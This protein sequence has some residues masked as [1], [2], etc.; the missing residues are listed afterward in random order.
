MRAAV[1]VAGTLIALGIF[2]TIAAATAMDATWIGVGMLTVSIS[3]SV[4]V[5]VASAPR[6]G[7]RMVAGG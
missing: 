7:R 3:G 5:M 6:G 1:A 2:L 4:G